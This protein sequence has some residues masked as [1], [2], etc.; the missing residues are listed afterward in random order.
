MYLGYV[1]PA[2]SRSCLPARDA[3]WKRPDTMQRIPRLVDRSKWIEHARERFLRRNSRTSSIQPRLSRV[4][5]LPY[6]PQ[7]CFPTFSSSRS[8]T[9]FPTLK[10]G[11]K[12][13][14]SDRR[15]LNKR[16]TMLRVSRLVRAR[17]LSFMVMKAQIFRLARATSSST[18]S[19]RDLCAGARTNIR[20][21]G[22]ASVEVRFHRWAKRVPNMP[23][24]KPHHRR[25]LSSS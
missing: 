3:R 25:D 6:D 17:A 8:S 18:G 2:N 11:E 24:V 20:Q 14:G 10:S 4:V 22:A 15:S 21:R 1:V 5:T 7:D 19:P 12:R 16:E 23:A 13:S 9:Q